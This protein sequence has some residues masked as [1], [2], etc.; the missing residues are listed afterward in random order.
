MLDI[1]AF[2]GRAPRGG[3]LP[4][5][6]YPADRIAALRAAGIYL[7]A[8]ATSLLA[9]AQRVAEAGVDAVVA[10]GIEAGGHR[11]VFD[12]DGPDELL[13]TFALTAPAGPPHRPAP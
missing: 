7:L 13:G 1:L 8:T 2:A 12:P 3:R 10:Q 5:R 9:E 4:F 11:G 6:P